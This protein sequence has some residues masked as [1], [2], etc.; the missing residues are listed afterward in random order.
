MKKF[1][2]M[3][4][5]AI[6]ALNVNVLSGQ[7]I[8]AADSWENAGYFT[9]CSENWEEGTYEFDN[10]N[11]DIPKDNLKGKKIKVTIEKEEESSKLKTFLKFISWAAYTALLAYV[12]F[13]VATFSGLNEKTKN[14]L[15]E[16]TEAN[17]KFLGD[18]QN[19]TIGYYNNATAKLNEA[20]KNFCP[21][22]TTNGFYDCLLKNLGIKP[23]NTTTS[24]GK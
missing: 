9:N 21:A 8:A 17:N 1:L 19:K 5:A 22:N 16:F 18:I 20:Y 11:F 6:M 12:G 7:N 2:S 24:E 14:K 23:M 3:A 15:G 4:L 13:T 10:L